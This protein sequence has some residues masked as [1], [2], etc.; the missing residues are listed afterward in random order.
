MRMND[1]ILGRVINFPNPKTPMVV[2]YLMGQ[3]LEAA[4]K[5]F[6]HYQKFMF[7]EDPEINLLYQLATGGSAHGLQ[8]QQ[9]QQVE[10]Q[11]LAGGGP[12]NQNGIQQGTAEQNTRQLA[13]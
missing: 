4:G 3:W 12:S 7:S 6:K 11:K 8:A 2:N 9:Q 10:Q 5:N 1:Q 13:G